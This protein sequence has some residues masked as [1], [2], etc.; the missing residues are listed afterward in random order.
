MVLTISSL[1]P[2]VLAAEIRNTSVPNQP[3]NVSSSR[4]ESSIRFVRRSD[5]KDA[6]T[7]VKQNVKWDPGLKK[8]PPPD[9]N[10]G[11]IKPNKLD[12][13]QYD[14]CHNGSG[15]SRMYRSNHKRAV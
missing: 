10:A 14:S 5:E 9:P 4:Q 2:G 13:S 11:Q 3:A 15:L 7:Q 1:S 8:G 6:K 12:G